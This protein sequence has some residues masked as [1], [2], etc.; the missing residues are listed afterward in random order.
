MSKDVSD[1]ELTELVNPFGLTTSVEI[2]RNNEGLSK[3]FGF[4]EYADES[5]ARAAISGLDGKDVHGQ[6]LKVSEAKPR[7]G[8]KPAAAPTVEAQ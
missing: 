7:K 1:A 8:D 3:G 6:A 2:V 5:H 4:V